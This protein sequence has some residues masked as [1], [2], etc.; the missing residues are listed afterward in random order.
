MKKEL[1]LKD[2]NFAH[3]L[4]SSNPTPPVN[5]TSDIIW[6]RNPAPAGVDVVCTDLMLN[7]GNI[8]W[9]LEPYAIHPF[10]YEH[11][12]NNASRYKEIWTHDK[13]YL[14]LPNA[15]FYPV[16]GC[17]LKEEDRRIPEKT[18]QFSIIASNKTQ[19]HGHKLRH[20]I[21]QAASGKVDAYGPSYIPFKEHSSNKI[22]GLKD[23]RYHF[24]IE[25]CRRDF[26]FSEKLIDCLMTGTI[27]I[28]WGCPSIGKFFNLDGIITFETLQ[29]LKEKL[30]SCTPEYY[31]SKKDVI[32]ENFELAKNYILPENWIAKNILTS[33]PKN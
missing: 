29:E 3:C 28:F 25:N 2:S 10:A 6:N 8:A 9:V 30:K 26:Y 5:L 24:V 16:G 7:D 15:K 11:I 1:Y 14:N 21:I 31:N 19:T 17:W 22:E 18:K 33:N 4:Y 20:Q 23:Y 27:P 12:K 13:E 32:K